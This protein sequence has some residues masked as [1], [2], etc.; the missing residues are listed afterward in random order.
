MTEA[1]LR[2]PAEA[3]ALGVATF[4][5][6]EPMAAARA[7]I[8]IT[9]MAVVGSPTAIAKTA[10]S[11]ACEPGAD[12]ATV[13]THVGSAPINVKTVVVGVTAARDCCTTH[14][15]APYSFIF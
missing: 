13:M 14:C 1:T 11:M 3:L 12:G 8:G 10:G 7:A 15:N 4:M 6:P 9:D 2:V 5:T